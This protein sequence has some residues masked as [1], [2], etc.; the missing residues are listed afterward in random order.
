M[1]VLS[2]TLN[3]TDNEAQLI[4]A[5]LS[6]DPHTRVGLSEYFVGAVARATADRNTAATVARVHLDLQNRIAAIRA[7]A[8]Q[9]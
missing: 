7:K 6:A 5:A 3:L 9:C 2:V 8:E 1:P 4:Y